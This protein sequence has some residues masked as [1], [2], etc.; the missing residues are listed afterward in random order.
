M[1]G[2]RAHAPALVLDL[3]DVAIEVGDPLPPLDRE[4]KIA[5][6]FGDERLDLAPEKARIVVGDVGWRREAEPLGGAGLGEFMEERVELALV[7]RVA[8]LADEVGGAHEPGF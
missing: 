8:E 3:E 1:P 2:M 4:L 5:E 6:G 7:E